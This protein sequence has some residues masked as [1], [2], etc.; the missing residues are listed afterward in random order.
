ML[1]RRITASILGTFLV[2]ACSAKT[3]KA[4]VDAG[5]VPFD[6]GPINP[7][8]AHQG[9]LIIQQASCQSCHG[10][11]LAGNYNGVTVGNTTITQYPPN[12]TPDLATGI[13]CW[14]DDQVVRAILYGVDNEGAVMC[15]PMPQW[16]DAGMTADEARSVVAFLRTLPPI[17][18][19]V[20]SGPDCTCMISSDCT[21]GLGCLNQICTPGYV[22]PI[23]GGINDG[24]I[25]DG[26]VNDG[27]ISDGGMN[28]GG[29]NDGGVSDGGISDG[30]VNDGG[31]NDAGIDDG[32]SDAG[33]DGGD[34]GDGGLDDGGMGDAGVDDGGAGDAGNADAGDGG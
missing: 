3:K 26:G 21:D 2:V 29:V 32:G 22:D 24:G 11:E 14:T 10:E 6:A 8:L 4:A 23:D 15:P 30:G 5:C 1:A 16:A 34:V 20:N 7:A 17:V 27:G 28:D 33:F 18:S 9:L 13:G 31:M 19:K 12:L 25:N